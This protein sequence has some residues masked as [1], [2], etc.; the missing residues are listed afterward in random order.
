MKLSL[1]YDDVSIIPQYSE[2]QSR[3]EISL[4]TKLTKKRKLKIPLV[5]SPMDTVVG[6]DM[7]IKMEKL[8]GI[9]FLPRFESIEDQVEIIIQFKE[10]FKND[11]AFSG[12]IGACIGVQEYHFNNAIKLLN[13]GVNIILIDIAHGHHIL[14]KNMM[15]K[16]NILKS[17]MDFEIIAGNIATSEAAKDL[18][19]WG[20]DCLRCGI[21]G[22]SACTTRKNSATG[23]PMITTISDI[24]EISKQHDVPL[25]ADGG[26]RYSGDV[27]KAIGAGAGTVMIGS[28]FA[29][30]DES[31]GEIISDG[32]S[33]NSTRM[34]EFRGSASRSSKID[35][36]EKNNNI[37]GI[38]K[39]IPYKGSVENIIISILDGLRSAMSYTGSD[40][41]PKMNEKC[42]FT[43]VTLNG[44][45]EAI[46]HISKIS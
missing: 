15:D 38:S 10:Y 35:R 12:N 29:G 20:A 2:I 11:E 28:L 6:L 23:I 4:K 39:L 21:G 36:G 13:A 31:P 42:S 27:G 14:M 16:L 30:T 19:D 46:P 8:G 41:I 32:F 22:G 33:L 40:T 3:S 18:I 7:M 24:Y 43:R 9:A 1:T 37:E 26:I 34:K 17:K 5:A 45:A 44:E 25:M